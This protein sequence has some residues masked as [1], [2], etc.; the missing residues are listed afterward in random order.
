MQPFIRPIL[1]FS[2]VWDKINECEHYQMECLNAALHDEMDIPKEADRALNEFFKPL[3][4]Q[5][6]QAALLQGN[7]LLSETSPALSVGHWQTAFAA[8]QLQRLTNPSIV[9]EDHALVLACETF[10]RDEETLTQLALRM[11]KKDMSGVDEILKAIPQG[12]SGLVSGSNSGSRVVSSSGVLD[13]VVATAEAS[14]S[15][16]K[17]K[18]KHVQRG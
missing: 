9:G 12:S 15:E 13:S 11:F 6:M 14:S 18:E 5:A 10:K 8:S 7:N 4:R 17:G 2:D 16:T 1:S 3:Y